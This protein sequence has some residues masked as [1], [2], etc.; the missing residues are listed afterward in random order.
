MNHGPL[1][2]TVGADVVNSRKQDY[3]LNEQQRIA[4]HLKRALITLLDVPLT[5]ISLDQQLVMMY[6]IDTGKFDVHGTPESFKCGANKPL[7]NIASVITQADPQFK[8]EYTIFRELIKLIASVN[9]DDIVSK[10]VSEL[11]NTCTAFSND[12]QNSQFV[13]S[14]NSTQ[15][16]NANHDDTCHHKNNCL[17]L[18]EM[19]ESCF[20]T[21]IPQTCV[22]K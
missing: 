1:D 8:F 15:S 9:M 19:L 17:P 16:P 12:N 20:A 22:I 6:L 2:P 4:F 18:R 14:Y 10:I 11:A 7:L 3:I 13:S 5:S 21:Y